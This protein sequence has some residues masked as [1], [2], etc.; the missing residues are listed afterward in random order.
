MIKKHD[1]L[2][3]EVEDLED[4]IRRKISALGDEVGQTIVK[5]FAGGKFTVAGTCFSSYF[6][7]HDGTWS[8]C[9]LCKSKD[10]PEEKDEEMFKAKE[11]WKALLVKIDEVLKEK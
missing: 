8:T 3:R 1:R 9:P 11:E 6:N 2:L 5:Y 10:M 7:V 4:E